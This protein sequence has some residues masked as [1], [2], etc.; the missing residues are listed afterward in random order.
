MPTA[1]SM[2]EMVSLFLAYSVFQNAIQ[3][4]VPSSM[5][6]QLG[7]AAGGAGFLTSFIL[8]VSFSPFFWAGFWPTDI[9]FCLCS[10]FFDYRTPI[11][12]VKCK[13]QVQ[14]MSFHPVKPAPAAP[15]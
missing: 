8:F 3:T 15:G 4:F 6:L 5:T 1:G 2:A 11:E 9:Y 13:M 10:P 7:P 12:L 14:M